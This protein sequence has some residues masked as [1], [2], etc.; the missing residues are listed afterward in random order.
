MFD[1]AGMMLNHS[2]DDLRFVDEFVEIVE[3][4]PPFEQEFLA[5]ETEPG[6]ELQVFCQN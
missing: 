6:C 4:V 5:D 1:I 3:I 2:M